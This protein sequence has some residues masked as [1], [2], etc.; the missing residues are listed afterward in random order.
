MLKQYIEENVNMFLELFECEWWKLCNSD[1]LVKNL[2]RQP[3]SY[4]CPLRQDQ[5]LD[6]IKSG[7]LSN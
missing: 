3:S 2:L 6:K 7:A 4:N 1:E 5:L